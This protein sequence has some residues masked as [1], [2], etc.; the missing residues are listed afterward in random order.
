MRYAGDYGGLLAAGVDLE[1][2]AGVEAGD[3]EAGG[4]AKGGKDAEPEKKPRGPAENK[5]ELTGVEERES[6]AVAG[7]VYHLYMLAAGG[8]PAVIQVCF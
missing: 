1:V 8:W 3:T 5:K 4:E 6:G 2:V 7:R